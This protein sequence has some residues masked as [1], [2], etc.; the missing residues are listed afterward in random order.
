MKTKIIATKIVTLGV[1]SWAFA[2]EYKTPEVGLKTV[3]P[4]E[5]VAK[6]AEFSDD[7]KVEGA[8]KA[9]R[10]IASE[11]DSDREPSSVVAEDEK[12]EKK[13]DEDKVSPEPWNYNKSLGKSKYE[14]K[15]NN[16]ER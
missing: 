3:T 2:S 14:N 13:S 15:W 4:T 10:Q 8:V 1:Y 11:E 9:D 12:E 16:L 5:T 6:T 7:Y